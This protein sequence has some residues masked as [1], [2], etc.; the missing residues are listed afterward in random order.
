A[1]VAAAPLE[2]RSGFQ[3]GGVNLAGCDFGMTTYGYSGVTWC[4]TT[5]QISHFTNQ[6]ANLIRLPVGWQYLVGSNVASTS[7]DQTYLATYDA[8]VQGVLNTGAYAIIDIHN[9]ARWNGGVVGT[10]VSGQY[11]ANLWSLLAA[12]Y[13][14]TRG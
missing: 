4:P 13:K 14:T 5:S 2:K 10:D 9:Y 1:A 12:K 11:F 6:G 8:L 7:L 3:F